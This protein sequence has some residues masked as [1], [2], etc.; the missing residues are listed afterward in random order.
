MPIKHHHP[1]SRAVVQYEKGNA[2]SKAAAQNYIAKYAAGC[3][4]KSVK[5]IPEPAGRKFYFLQGTFVYSPSV[6]Q[7][8][9]NEIAYSV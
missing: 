7:S 1:P 4:D 8:C 3:Y 9:I 6:S 2:T 5:I